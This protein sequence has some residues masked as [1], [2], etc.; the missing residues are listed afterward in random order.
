MTTEH[1]VVRSGK[2]KRKPFNSNVAGHSLTIATFGFSY[3]RVSSDTP[4]FAAFT[5][6]APGVRFKDHHRRPQSGR[7]R[8][9]ARLHGRGSGQSAYDLFKDYPQSPGL[10]KVTADASGFVA[11]TPEGMAGTSR[12]LP[13][14]E[15]AAAGVLPYS[16][17]FV[18]RPDI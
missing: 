3:P 12:D 7:L 17:A 15:A 2:L 13:A 14:A 18:V 6:V 11:L 9:R 16:S 1:T 10:K 4:S 8:R 5:P